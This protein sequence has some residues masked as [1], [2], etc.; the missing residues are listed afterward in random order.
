MAIADIL[1]KAYSEIIIPNKPP[2][3]NQGIIIQIEGNYN[4]IWLGS[5]VKTKEDLIERLKLNTS[6][7][8]INL[9]K[10]N[11]EIDSLRKSNKWKRIK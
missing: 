7:D 8:N 4:N 6:P 3:S 5:D 10:A 11:T 2:E 9:V 1:W